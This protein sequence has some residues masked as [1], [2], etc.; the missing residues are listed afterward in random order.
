VLSD[1]RVRLRRLT[2]L[3]AVA[4]VAVV[5]VLV[6]PGP[7]RSQRRAETAAGPTPQSV[8]AATATTAAPAS[9]SVPTVPRTTATSRPPRTTSPPTLD[10]GTLPQTGQLPSASDALLS[11][12]VQ[13]L[14]RAVVDG[15]PDEATPFF[16]PLDAYVQVKSISDPVH[17]YQTRLIPNFDQDVQALHA[18]LGVAA[19][20]ARLTGISVPDAAQWIVPG[21][22]YNKGSYWRVYGTTLNYSE[23]GTSRSFPITSLISWRGEWY[24]V[25]LGAIR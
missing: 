8:V 11:A 12:H 14:W 1:R 9:S 21:V 13:D 7:S 5:V 17:D 16:F 4:A 19:S 3:V 23:G 24:V 15:R 20:S 22:E 18:E 10:P 6:L 25:H 2:V